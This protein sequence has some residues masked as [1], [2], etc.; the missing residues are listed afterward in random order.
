MHQTARKTSPGNQ[1][2]AEYNENRTDE[3]AG[4]EKSCDGWLNGGIS[5]HAHCELAGLTALLLGIV[6]NFHE[7]S[8]SSHS[9]KSAAITENN[10]RFEPVVTPPVE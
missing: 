4:D 2:D 8:F 9:D 1:P 10:D 5:I 6:L 3:S 7:I